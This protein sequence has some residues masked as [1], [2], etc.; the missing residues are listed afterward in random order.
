MNF[1]GHSVSRKLRLEARTVLS[2]MRNKG[3]HKIRIAHVQSVSP[4]LAS[5]LQ[6]IVDAHS[7]A[8]RDAL[9]WLVH[10]STRPRCACG[11][12]VVLRF[13]AGGVPLACNKPYG[14]CAHQQERQRRRT[15][16]THMKKYG[17]DH[18][19]RARCVQRTRSKNCLAKYGVS[20]TAKL[21]SVRDK[22]ISTNKK[23]YGVANTF[24]HAEFKAKACATRLARY[25]VEHMSQSR[26]SRRK[27]EKTCLR[28]YGTTNPAKSNAVKR[29][30]RKTCLRKYGVPHPMQ[31]VSVQHR[32]VVAQVRS[33]RIKLGHRTVVV[34]GYEPIALTYLQTKGISASSIEV[35]SDRTIPR[36]LWIDEKGKRHY[37][38]PDL[39]VGRRILEVKSGWT[40]YGNSKR[41][42]V[43][44]RKARA[45]IDA[46]YR[47]E[48]LLVLVDTVVPLP[49]RW[50][51]WNFSDMRKFAKKL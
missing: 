26:N 5:L 4:L 18:S 43:C 21:P 51:N 20:H 49:P 12:E 1:Y 33:K 34:Q 39:K 35:S 10:P 19:S 41:F 28:R 29:R 48:L 38:F 32:N 40:L 25:G 17:V 27:A 7:F 13:R 30:A 6:T 46:G 2:A 3:I 44:K 24:Q 9:S 8:I 22:C 37:Y 50:L 47:F 45:A 11:S 14:S 36:F 15:R 42:D 23:R 31:D 16:I